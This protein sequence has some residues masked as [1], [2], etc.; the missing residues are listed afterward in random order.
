MKPRDRFAME[1]S[2]LRFLDP[3]EA[4]DELFFFEQDR[5]VRKDNVFQVENIRYE[6]PRDLSGRTIQ[7]RYRRGKIDRVIVYYKG[8][9]IGQA[10]PLDLIANDRPSPKGCGRTGCAPE[11]SHSS[12]VHGHS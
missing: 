12:G 3:M 1:T 4:N 10:T 9:R 6:C 8:E 2:R 7:V 11:R 5:S